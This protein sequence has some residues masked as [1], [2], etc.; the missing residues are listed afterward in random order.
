MTRRGRPSALASLSV[1]DLM[2]E[3]ERRRSVLDELLARR[4]QLENDMATLEGEIGDLESLTG[5][6]GGGG[7]GRRGRRRGPGRPR[8]SGRRGPAPGH[9]RG[10]GGGA[11]GKL[12][13]TRRGRGSNKQSLVSALHSALG[14]RTLSVA[15][16]ADAVQ[17]SGYKTTS[18]NFRTIVNAALI[19]NPDKF[20]RVARGQYTAK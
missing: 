11:A 9:A 6:G 10:M 14:G 7:R 8:G 2:R 15:E 13:G 3:V 20:K 16:M 19:T 12:S 4:A 5:G 18:P 17:K 1:A